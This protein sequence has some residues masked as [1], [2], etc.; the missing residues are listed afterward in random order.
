[1][2]VSDGHVLGK[3]VAGADATSGAGAAIIYRPGG[4]KLFLFFGPAAPD[5]PYPVLTSSSSK[6]E[7]STL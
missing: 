6:S 1:V 2:P 4:C 5:E 3:A 7:M